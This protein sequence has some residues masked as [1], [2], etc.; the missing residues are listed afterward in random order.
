MKDTIFK[1]FQ[2]PILIIIS[3]VPRNPLASRGIKCIAV[4]RD[5]VSIRCC[6]VYVRKCTHSI[7]S[8]A[9]LSLCPI[10]WKILKL[11]NETA[12]DIRVKIRIIILNVSSKHFL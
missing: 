9:I 7:S 6:K 5:L 3:Q 8:V 11:K 10:F 2:F 12:L 1:A 4:A